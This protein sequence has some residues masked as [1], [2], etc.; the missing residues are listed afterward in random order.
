MVDR[1]LLD[2]LQTAIPLTERPFLEIAKQLGTS[3]ADVLRRVGAMQGIIR[4]ISAIFDSGA[5]GYQSTLVAAKVAEEKIDEAAK[6]INQH[7]GVSHNYKRDGRGSGG[8]HAF[9][10][11]Y[12]LGVPRGGGGSR[13]GLEKTVE[14]LHRLSGAELT[15]MMPTER[16]F[17]IGVRFDLG[18]GFATPQSV[19]DANSRDRQLPLTED[20]KKFVQILQQNLPL[21]A[22]PFT[23]WAKQNNITVESLFTAARDF[24]ERKW[25]RRFAAV[26]RHRNVG[27]AANA[28]GVW[29]VHPEATESFGQTAATFNAVSHCYLRQT[30]SDWPFNMFTMV[31]ATTPQQCEGVLAAISRETGMTNYATLYSTKEYKKQRVRYFTDDV[32]RW[33]QEI[34]NAH[35]GQG[36]GYVGEF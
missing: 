12:T 1:E 21:T 34:M 15:R 5:L 23:V 6:I 10:L 9:N 13:L 27:I 18:A 33:E 14:I 36:R 7:P 17:K 2:I 11:W 25:M 35:P 4:Q 8:W 24:L 31:H 16:V 22:E 28:M 32:E 29:V 26:L 3:E 20:D 19:F 30:H